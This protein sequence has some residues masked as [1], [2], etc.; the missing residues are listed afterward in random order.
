MRR[1]DML[2]DG[3]TRDGQVHRDRAG[4]SQ[5]CRLPGRLLHGIASSLSQCSSGTRLGSARTAPSASRVAHLPPSSPRCPQ[6]RLSLWAPSWTASTPSAWRLAAPTSCHATSTQP[7]RPSRRPLTRC[8]VLRRGQAGCQMGRRT[9]RW[10]HACGDRLC[11]SWFARSLAASW[12]AGMCECIL[13]GHPCPAHAD[14]H[15]FFQTLHPFF[16]LLENSC[17]LI[18]HSFLFVASMTFALAM[19]AAAGRAGRIG[20][21]AR[22]ACALV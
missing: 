22:W 12:P 3:C 20:C 18:L 1:L 7:G 4:S 8:W 13:T 15:P 19:L 5:R 10:Q 11:T 17:K 6:A 14:R 9:E 16:L 21:Q 2:Q